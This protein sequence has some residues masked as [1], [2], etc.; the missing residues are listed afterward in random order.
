MN[1][2]F[3]IVF[4]LRGTVQE[5]DVETG[6][7]LSSGILVENISLTLDSSKTAFS[8]RAN[9]SVRYDRKER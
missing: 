6:D 2:K 9:S 7:W 8:L 3:M 5:E 1:I 4:L